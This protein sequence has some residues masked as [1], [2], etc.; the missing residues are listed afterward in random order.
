MNNLVGY[1]IFISLNIWFMVH[2]KV[3][4]VFVSPKNIT[5][6]SNSP[7]G[8]LKAAFHSSPSLI[9]MLLYPHHMLNLVKS[10]LP[11]SCSRMVFVID[12]TNKDSSSDDEE[13]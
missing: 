2:W 10:G 9:L 1:H 6:G 7:L 5:C 4:R 12:L 13:L 11:C 3:A 8:V